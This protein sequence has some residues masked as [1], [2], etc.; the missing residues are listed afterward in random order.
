MKSLVLGAIALAF[1]GCELQP[2]E[3]K[4]DEKAQMFD[5]GKLIY[6]SDCAAFVKFEVKDRSM[7]ILRLRDGN[8]ITSEVRTFDMGDAAHSYVFKKTTCN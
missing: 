2:V 8:L 7:G 6:E 4:N 5:H 1:M 3:F